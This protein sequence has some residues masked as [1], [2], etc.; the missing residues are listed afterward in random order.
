MPTASETR[1]GPFGIKMRAGRRG[2]SDRRPENPR[3]RPKRTSAV[4]AKRGAK[5][6]RPLAP[7]G[8]AA[9]A[10]AL[11]VVAIGRFSLKRVTPWAGVLAVRVFGGHGA[12]QALSAA[13]LAVNAVRCRHAARALNAAL[14][15]AAERRGNGAGF[16][17]GGLLNEDA[18]TKAT[19]VAVAGGARLRAFDDANHPLVILQDRAPRC[20][21]PRCARSVCRPSS[22]I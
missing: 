4:A 21:A 8:K 2:G 19:S 3:S 9:K 17:K 18:T 5:G 7:A 10:G 13:T 15:R 16:W 14:A 12:F 1:A 20:S 22:R 11:A 6:S